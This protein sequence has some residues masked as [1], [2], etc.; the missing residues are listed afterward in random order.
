MLGDTSD[1]ADAIPADSREFGFDNQAAVQSVDDL[2]A[3]KYMLAAENLA[4]AAVAELDGLLPCD[5]DE[6]G[7]TACAIEFVET[8][9]R[10]AYRRPLLGEDIDRL[11][12]AYDSARVDQGFSDGIRLLITTMLQSPHFLYRV[13]LGTPDPASENVVRLTSYELAT[14]LSYLLWGTM[15]DD[16]LSAA[17]DADELTS[18]EQL[19][20]QARRLLDDPRARDTVKRFHSMWLGLDQLEQITKDPAVYPTFHDGIPELWQ[21]EHES[22]IEHVVFDR[23]GTINDLLTAPFSLMNNELAAFYE[24]EGATSDDY[25]TVVDLDPTRHAGILTQGG[26]LA[27]QSSP[28]QTNPVKRGIFV[29]LHLMCEDIPPPPSD[30]VVATP[31]LDPDLTTRERYSQHSVDPACSSCHVRM[32]P[33]GFGFENYDAVGLWR[34]AEQAGPID[35]SGEIFIADDEG[36]EGSFTGVVELAAKL[37]QSEQ[38][39]DC[40]VSQWFR[41]GYG[42]DV[43]DADSCSTNALT[44]GVVASGGNIIELLVA[45]TQTDA[46]MY[47]HAVEGE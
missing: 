46:F 36:L 20:T 8:F 31:V 5:P 9:G 10:R 12:L 11:M 1:E 4:G 29:R 18:K 33:I 39:R 30:I 28:D 47:R 19:A 35:A 2:L 34:D 26:L 38:V 21:A 45:L 22:F 25:F 42:R 16:V 44:N 14:R 6:I 3:E 40:I 7:E 15:P 37:A 13:E 17:A 43:S 32:D 41:F 23:A 27:V 24:V